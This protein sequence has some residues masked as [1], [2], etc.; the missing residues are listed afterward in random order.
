MC[1]DIFVI[2]FS[3]CI[4]DVFVFGKGTLSRGVLNYPLDISVSQDASQKKKIFFGGVYVC[5][6]IFSSGYYFYVSKIH[7]FGNLFCHI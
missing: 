1:F 7:K 5:H 6:L 3:F 2:I 4:T